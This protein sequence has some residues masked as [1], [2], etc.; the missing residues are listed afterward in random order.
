MK[1]AE[2]G[3]AEI[4]CVGTELLLGDIVNT[5][6]AYLSRMLASLGISV[7][8]EGVV[9]DNADRLAEAIRTALSRAD[10]LIL[11]GGL[12]P[13]CDDI[14]KEVVASVLGRGM[15]VDRESEE[16]MKKFFLGIGKKM[17]PNNIRQVTLPEG[18][19]VFPNDYGIAP[20]VALEASFEGRQVTVIMLPGPPRELEGLCRDCVLPY[21]SERSGSVIVSK[22][23]NIAGMGESEAEQHL[24][25]LMESSQNPTVAPYC[26]DGEMRVRVTARADSAEAAELL[27]ENMLEKIRETAVAPYIYDIDSPSVEDTVI[28]RLR[29]RGLTLAGAESCTG[30]LIGKKL[31]DIPG[32][33]EVYLGGAVTYSNEAKQKM[34]GVRHETLERYGAVS[35]QT[36]CEMARGIR[37]CLGA[38]IGIS[39]TGIAGPGG[40]SPD[41]PVGTVWIAISTEQATKATLLHLSSARPRSHIRAN[42]AAR[43]L[44]QVLEYLKG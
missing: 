9:G 1:K 21:L 44:C 40:G 35:E 13:T 10:L 28:R 7:F 30:G 29:E 32:C 18:A 24:R 22:N 15:Y 33:S 20:G 11:G 17:T 27:C 4:I 2:I 34:L 8:R 42:A 43:A 37:E 19:I 14:T 6:A 38:D 31:T 39:T 12:G 23:V 36:A 41:K 26:G 16:R 5:N 3:S 25:G